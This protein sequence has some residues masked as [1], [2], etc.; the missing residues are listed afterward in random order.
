MEEEK[1][2][3]LKVRRK[4]YNHILKFP[5]IHKRE[6][7]RELKIPLSTLDYHLHYLEKRGLITIQ[8]D[9]TYVRY[10]ASRDLGI[11]EKE[12]LAI[13]R[14]KVPRKILMYLLLQMQSSHRSIGN[15]LG[16][17]P[18]T[19]SYH[20]NKLVDLEAIDRL[21]HGRETAYSIKEP[22]YIT[23]LLIKYR[24]SFLD[25]AVDRFIE[26]WF[27]L[28]PKHLRKTKRKDKK[29]KTNFLMLILP[30]LF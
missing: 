9:G 14:Q 2:L 13:L 15:H 27:E 18:S 19:T 22:E 21:Q 7:A 8:L 5:A 1:T 11:K 12:I 30:L 3:E 23:D 24:E 25:A 17:A 29:E 16:L 4:I 26:T 28:H 10:H 20:L 6:L